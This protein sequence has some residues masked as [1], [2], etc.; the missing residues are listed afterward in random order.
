[1]NR[2]LFILSFLLLS[3]SA[4]AQTGGPDSIFTFECICG[5]LSPQDTN[6]DICTVTLQSRFFKGVLIRRYGVPY[7][8]I[9]QPYTI[10]FQGLNATFE[11]LIPAPEKIT[12]AMQATVFDTLPDYK[13][14]VMCPCSGGKEYVAGDGIYFV[15]DTINA[16][17]PDTL[18][19]AWTITDGTNFEVISDQI[20]TFAGASG[21]TTSYNPATNTLTITAGGGGSGDNWGS[22]VVQHDASLA[23]D[24]TAGNPLGITGYGAAANGEIPSKS[25]GGITWITVDLSSTNEIQALTA[26]D[27]AGD[28]KTL[29]LSLGGGTVTLDP[30]G[31]LTISR[32]GNTL[33]LTATEVDGSVTNE[34]WTVDADD[35]DTEVI[36]NQTVKFQGGGITTTDYN[37]ATDVLLI[38]SNEVDGSVTNEGILGVAAGAST[39]S[40][41]TSNTVGANGVT[42]S[43]A[44]ILTISETTST[45]GGTI[46]LTATEVDGSVTNEIQTY[47][48]SGTT[49]YT[50]TLSL[51]GGSFTLQS[52]G[53]VAIAHSS[54]TVTISAT[55]V[56]GSTTNEIQT[57]SHSGTSSYTNTL[58]LGGGSFTLQASGIVTISNSSGT[59]TISA[60]EV[61][62]SITNEGILGVA[63]GIS[64]TSVITS[65][66]ST[67]NGV[68]ISVAG[69]LT[70]GE[71]TSTNGGTITLTATEVDGSVT[72]EAWTVDADDADTEVISNQTV[73]FQ[74]A[75]IA[76]T[77]YNPATDVLLITATEVDGSTTNEIQTI[78]AS[79]GGPTSFNIDL[80]LS[81]GSVTLAEG[82]GVD[83][84]RSG[85]T[86]TIASSGDA[87]ITNE[88]L[89][90]VSA[91][92]TNDALLTSNTSGA[93]G[94]TYAGT[95]GIVITES[96]SSNGGTITIA[97][98]SGSNTNTMRH[99]G[100]A[101]V[102]S[103]EIQNNEAEVGIGGAPISGF[104]LYV[105]GA[106]R[107]D[108]AL[109]S[110]GVG[111]NFTSN[112]AAPHLRLWNTTVAPTTGDIWYLGSEDDGDFT[113]TS[114]NLGG[115]VL[116]A[117]ATTGQVQVSSTLRIGSVTGTPTS[118]IGRNGTGDV[119]QITVGSG[120]SFSGGT[121]SATGGGITTANN[122]LYVSGG[123]TVRLG[124][125]PLIE[126][127]LIDH[128]G[129]EYRH[130]D[131]KISLTNQATSYTA[132]GADFGVEGTEAVPTLNSTPTKDAI[133]ELRASNAGS[134]QPNSLAIGAYTTDA[135]GIWLQARSQA[136]PN[137]EYPLSLQPRG[138]QMSVGRVNGLD[139]LV[140]F[141]GTGLAG[142]G[143]AGQV[144]HLE[145][146]EGNG[147]TS[148]SMGAGTDALDSEI[149]WFD[150]TDALR[151]TNR[152]ATNGTSTVR[153]AIGGET[154]DKSMWVLSATTPNVR[155]G[156]GQTA[157]ANVTSTLHSAGSFATAILT[158]VGAVTLDE[159]H[160]VVIFTGNTNQTWT[161]P[162]ASTCTGRQY[163]LAHRNTTATITL[164]TSINKGNGGSFTTISPGEWA[165]IWSDGSAWTGY[166][167]TS[168]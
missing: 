157:P 77:D 13:A 136:V 70:I 89:L 128:N 132:Q 24:G 82:A 68:T 120:L 81:G 93:V 49:S 55:E 102:A 40:I 37:P 114:S 16:V 123:T 138:G 5:Y 29:D 131:G 152:S 26:G 27:G 43:V 92:G 67:A 71:T 65:N 50:N 141:S 31:I 48:H 147:K 143:I 91:G 162:T 63:A 113:L 111:S 4:R 158:T 110:R 100:S 69:I 19:E 2:F 61:D 118:I 51:G 86:I 167:L 79:G 144:L 85:N 59:V 8:W 30:A 163:I 7:K 34:A 47:A 122:G 112:L 58:S 150:A 46:T 72:N 90:G 20:V 25:G 76:V 139:A 156:V 57:Y 126:T 36:S 22:Q 96:V 165:T 146:N 98:P 105:N 1:M 52:G 117:K 151:L 38:T 134:A 119:G 78:S 121:L 45:N 87:S 88:G 135:D 124:T 115:I 84:T 14:A 32:S 148:M 15:G 83:L 10:K 130:S 80:S 11:E 74:G 6:C 161:L 104:E 44:G 166:K 28:N 60:T 155:Y 149:A 168:L 125:N 17:D 160:H 106:Q 41:I 116:A 107:N 101:W 137:F 133:V 154:S 145:N 12:I 127:T 62:G 164:S 95:N 129:F 109:V 142:S 33:T 73:K 75:G 159:R 140:T 9:E 64:T 97:M 35:A 53:I 103:T 108:G 56:D 42:L 153:V 18:N 94:V 99:N 54:G 39:T 21:A 23:G 66:T 3:L